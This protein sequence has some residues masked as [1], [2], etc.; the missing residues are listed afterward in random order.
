LRTAARFAVPFAALWL[1]NAPA[2]VLASY[3]FALLFAWLAFEQ[4]SAAP[5]LWGGLGT[6]LGLGLAGF[7]ILPAAYE[8]HWVNI[9]QVLS[10]GLLPSENFL[11]TNFADPEHDLFN[12]IAS[13]VSILLILVALAA[14]F[15]VCRSRARVRRPAGVPPDSARF[16]RNTENAMLLLAAASIFLML[17]LSSF[18]WPIL[19]KLRFVQFPWRWALILAIP[20]AFLLGLAFE[21]SRR[22]IVWVLAL[23]AVS[24]ASAGYLITHT[25]WDTDDMPSLADALAEQQG[26]EGTDEYDPVGD[27]HYDLA[28]QA[29]QAAVLTEDAEDAPRTAI[30]VLQW[31]AERK[32]LRV[33]SAEPS[34]I[35]LRL[36]NYPAWQVLVNGSQILP[37]REG[38]T[39]QMI[40]PVPRGTSEISVRFQRTPDRT[41]GGAIALASLAMAGFCLAGGIRRT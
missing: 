31:T 30:T 26:F 12:W 22:R 9:G 8:Q 27:D 34:R 14:A 10:S 16:G 29:P 5:L 2:G 1:S 23:L 39:A 15:F 38:Q 41:I 37:L 25:W 32:E 19:P 35:A 24:G 7:Y 17:R 6:A 13:T 40:V 4:R 33:V 18:L 28:A 3:S 20:Y 11:Y 36:L 21:K